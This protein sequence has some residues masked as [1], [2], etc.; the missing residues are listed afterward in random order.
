VLGPDDDVHLPTYAEV[1]ER[2]ADTNP[3]MYRRASDGKP[4][5]AAHAPALSEPAGQDALERDR[6]R[7]LAVNAP[8]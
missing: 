5:S 7:N 6:Q 4:N 8:P 3:A 2:I 1:V